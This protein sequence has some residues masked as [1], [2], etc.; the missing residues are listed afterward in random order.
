VV[1]LVNQQEKGAGVKNDVE[2][3]NSLVASVK[4]DSDI[5]AIIEEDGS[6]CEHLPSKQIF[7]DI[8]NV[9]SESLDEVGEQFPLT[10]VC[11]EV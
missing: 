10:M 2:I 11:G 8:L 5:M 1:W 7:L 6:A 9:N 4:Q 3:L